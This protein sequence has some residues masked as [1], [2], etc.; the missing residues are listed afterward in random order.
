MMQNPH[1]AKRRV[2]ALLV[3][4]GA[5]L[6]LFAAVLYDAQILHGGE[7]RAKSISSNAASE[8]VTA[9]RGI[10]TDRNGKV[11]VSNRLAYTL[12][13]DR[14]GF[15]DDAAL[16]AAILRLVQLC[17]ET[18]TGWNDTLPIGR[19]GNF[20]RY[21]NAR[22]E[23]FD[24]FI[25]KNDLTSGASGRQLLS[26]LRELYH[27]DESLSEREARLIVGV[28][29]E[30][31]SRDSYT[32]AEDV[33]TE[34]LSLITDGRYEG[35]TIRTASAR[36]YNTAL[37]AH[38]LGTI[39]PIW[40]EE[41][42]SSED[43]GYV[44]Y[45]DKGYSMN[46]LVGKDGVEKAFESYLRGMDGRRLITTDETGK[47]TGELYTREPQPGGTVALTLDIDL[48]ADVEAALAETISGMIDKDS[49]ER[50][51]A[52]AVVSV[53]TGEV[54]ALAS[55]P[56]Y[57]LSTFN[58]DYDELVNDQRLPMFNRATQGIYA[59]GSTFK[60]VTAVAALESG[61]IT[62]SSIIQD[63]GI[64]TYYKDPQP[65]C[66]I[67]SQTGSTHGRINVS[68]AITDSCNYFFYEVGRLTG[69]RTLDSYASQ[70][71]LGQST[72]IE[73]GDS[74]GVLASPEWAESHDQ[75]W[76]D[77][78]TITAAIGQSYNLFTPLQLANYVATLVGGGDHY[79]AHLL[80]NVKAYD[81]S[82]LLYMYGDKP[83]NTVEI[84]DSTL[85]AV[86]RGMH[87]LTVSGSVAYAFEN[88]VVSAGAKTG[89]AQVGT[90]IA[91]G[92]FVAYVP[93][94]KPEIAVAIVIEK[95]GSGA[96]LA[97]TA[98]EIINSWFSRAQD[99]TA[100]GENTLLK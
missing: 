40:Q 21:S 93:Y 90:D 76:T 1:P 85:S 52:A 96:A 95:G 38:I 27:V 79:Q 64:Y 61:I 46:D 69:I 78:Q 55:Y 37:A 13:F 100:I 7:N 17:E 60:M 65:M 68:Q 62:P 23:T 70:F 33:S 91:N 4:F 32:F 66:W 11:L 42:S 48:Q 10:I 74:S 58:E 51:G 6:L 73:I 31:H 86:T 57:D 67:Y 35:V 28:R 63:R 39:G 82:R 59:P 87:E 3:F 24:K 88:C 50:G 81:N 99:G 92:V 89:S 9:S 16:N 8:T 12:V 53:G 14:S 43:T 83:M 44:G 77:G 15:D 94:E 98:V 54:L 2:I 84:S 45:A 18:G 22:S 34:V 56:T 19:V 20:L 71:G 80:K 97:N 5:F 25:E 75:E 36:V 41:W 26:E 49:N 47:I 72:G 30:L 29:Y